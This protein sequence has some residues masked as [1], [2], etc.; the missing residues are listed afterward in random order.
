MKTGTL[1]STFVFLY[2]NLLGQDANLTKGVF[3]NFFQDTNKSFW[4]INAGGQ[5]E[6]AYSLKGRLLKSGFAGRLTLTG[7]SNVDRFQFR[8]KYTY[9]EEGLYWRKSTIVDFATEARYLRRLTDHISFGLQSVFQDNRINEKWDDPDPLTFVAL[10]ASTEL[11]LFPYEKMNKYRLSF[12]YSFGPHLIIKDHK[13]TSKYFHT[14]EMESYRIWNWVM[15]FARASLHQRYDN[16]QAGNISGVL[17]TSL[18][19]YKRIFINA[20]AGFNYYDEDF[21]DTVYILELPGRID[22]ENS[23]LVYSYFVGLA[24]G[25]GNKHMK[26]QNIQ[27]IY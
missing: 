18:R 20:G 19:V 25:F 17:G 22:I 13:T 26:F 6:E 15:A 21:S 14:I 4:Q 23:N 1:L 9:A 24:Y 7:Q 2:F 11:N 12:L 10:K 5:Y 8:A 27:F 16:I 3:S